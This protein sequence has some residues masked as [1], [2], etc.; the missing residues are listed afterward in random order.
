MVTTKASTEA[1]R[2]GA[3]RDHRRTALCLSLERDAL[4]AAATSVVPAAPGAPLPPS[5]LDAA[6]LQARRR[7]EE[8]HA[9]QEEAPRPLPQQQLL[10]VE[11]E[12][13]T[14]GLSVSGAPALPPAPAATLPTIA[15]VAIAGV[16]T[17]EEATV[18]AE[19]ATVAAAVPSVPSVPTESSLAESMLSQCSL[20][21]SALVD[22]AAAAPPLAE[23]TATVAAGSLPPVVA[24]LRAG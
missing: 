22:S 13:A 7:E 10:G 18:A 1:S 5:A 11:A 4:T 12:Q 21:D 19:E 14:S 3:P 2:E 8:A 20:A 6:A 16:A 23:A 24:A 9:G 15:P 17:A